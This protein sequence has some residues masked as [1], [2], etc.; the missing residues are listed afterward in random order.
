MEINFYILRH[1][2]TVY[3]TEKRMQGWSDSPLT[4]KGEK[5]ASQL[6]ESLKNFRFDAVFTSDLGRAVKTSE[7]VME[8]NH[9]PAPFF[10]EQGLREWGLGSLE[11]TVSYVSVI[12]AALDR[13]KDSSNTRNFLEN[14]A[15]SARERDASKKAETYE[16]ARDRIMSTMKGAAFTAEK[17]SWKDILVVTHG[18]AI[19]TILNEITG[20]DM[21][22]KVIPNLTLLK[23]VYKD[24]YFSYEGEHPAPLA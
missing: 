7:L 24:G 17:N 22:G 16:K 18:M 13:C 1:G 4:E 14:F 3:N 19:L 5:K 8:K 12:T 21:A 15:I 6:G 20:D 23:I 9:Y 11:G 2:E 10:T